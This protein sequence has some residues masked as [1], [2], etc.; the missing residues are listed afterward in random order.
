MIWTTNNFRS[1]TKRQHILFDHEFLLWNKFTE[2]LLKNPF[3]QQKNIRSIEWFTLLGDIASN[4][5]PTIRMTRMCSS[6]YSTRTH[7]MRLSTLD[8]LSIDGDANYRFWWN[9]CHILCTLKSVLACYL[10]GFRLTFQA[11]HNF[12]AYDFVGFLWMDAFSYTLNTQTIGFYVFD[13]YNSFPYDDADYESDWKPRRIDHNHTLVE[14][15]LP[16]PNH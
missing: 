16:H 3:F 12:A 11:P 9:W 1:D 6:I 5:L 14:L 15:N 2:T 8:T 7:S 4:A 10:H 13:F